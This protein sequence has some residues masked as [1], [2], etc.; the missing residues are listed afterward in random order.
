LINKLLAAEFGIHK[1]EFWKELKTIT[2]EHN[3]NV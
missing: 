1:D 2:E 3:E